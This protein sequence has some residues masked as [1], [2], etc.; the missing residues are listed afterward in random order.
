M[1]FTLRFPPLI[2]LLSSRISE[3]E[4]SAMPDFPGNTFL[5][6]FLIPKTNSHS[7]TLPLA[8]MRPFQTEVSLTS[9]AA[10]GYSFRLTQN[11]AG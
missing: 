7:D 9:S 11:K 1:L 2:S 6:Y 5:H 8:T 3:A 10:D 4:L